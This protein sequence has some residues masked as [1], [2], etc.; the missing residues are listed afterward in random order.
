M[1]T[2]YDGLVVTTWTGNPG[3]VQLQVDAAPPVVRLPLQALQRE[4]KW[5][6]GEGRVFVGIDLTGRPPT[7]LPVWYRI[8]GWD[9]DHHTLIMERETATPAPRRIQRRRVK[10]WRL[11]A[12]A[13]IVDRTSAMYGNPFKVGEPITREPWRELFGPVVR[14]LAH[15]VE[16]FTVYA[17]ITSGYDILVRHD[18]RGRDLA[19][20]CDLPE[21]G[22]P[23]ICH[24][25]VLIGIANNPDP[26][27]DL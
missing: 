4:H 27:N 5:S 9:T 10:G 21:P 6:V 16:I 15:A 26:G 8:T 3:G 12:G 1:R 14:D 24:A 22:Q 13:V 20:T 11:P 18:L 23:D 7:R 25:A 2:D 19:C 17:R